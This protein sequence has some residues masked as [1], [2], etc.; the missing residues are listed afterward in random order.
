MKKL[1]F[2][3]LCAGYIA[4]TMAKTVSQ[5]D[6]AVPYAIA[7]RDLGRA[8]NLADKYGFQK[9]YGSYEALVNDEN[10]DL[11]YIAS[12]HSH[13]YEHG[14]LCLEHGKHVLCEKP[15]TVNAEQGEELFAL[16]KSRN[17]FIVEAVWTRFQPFA[18]K[19]HEILDSGMIGTPYTLTATFGAD[20]TRVERIVSP[21][22][23]GGSLLDQGIYSLTFA[24]MFFGTEIE[25]IHSACVKTERGVD[26][27]DSITLVYKDGRMA[28]LNQSFLC[29]MKNQGV[30]YGSK[31]R[32]EVEPFWH[33]EEIRVYCHDKAE[34]NVYPVPFDITGYEYEVRA[35]VKAIERGELGCTEVPHGET[36]R[37]LRIM[38]QLRAE[39]GIHYPFE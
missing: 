11:I 26:A 37:I 17:L 35:A 6:E 3:I 25:D 14:K 34:P 29:A 1:N 31:G 5:M 27:Q 32:V 38:D 4:E 23:A 12:P 20:L 39:W 8:Q 21:E 19:I 33:P 22:L 10:V 9:A 15:F 30:I 7:A 28:V 36:L 24:S 13:H 18:A 2:A 16:A